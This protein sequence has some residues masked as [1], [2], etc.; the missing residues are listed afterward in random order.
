MGHRDQLQQVVVLHRRPFRNSSL[1]VDLLS[2]RGSRTSLVARG[3]SRGRHPQSA[4][5]EPFRLI[6]VSWSGRGELH[7]LNKL[8]PTAT[9]W[10]L[11]GR[12]LICGLYANELLMRTLHH[13]D[14]HPSLFEDYLQ[15]V[16][17]LHSEADEGWL[18]RR[19]EVK[20]LEQVGFGVDLQHDGEGIPIEA[21]CH[22]HYHPEEGLLPFSGNHHSRIVISGRTLQWLRSTEAGAERKILREARILLRHAI[23]YHIPGELQSRKLMAQY[24]SIS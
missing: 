24:S 20:L 13:G 19:F 22:Y 11:D 15:L 14:E 7:T 16:D 12:R 18:L 6:Q 8:E 10:R 17:G 21:D 4:L 2:E 9:I 23:D 1:N 3:A 5:L